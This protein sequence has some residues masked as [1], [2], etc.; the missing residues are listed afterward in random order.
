MQRRESAPLLDG[1]PLV[2]AVL[3]VYGLRIPNQEAANLTKKVITLSLVLLVTQAIIS[4]IQA[5][6]YGSLSPPLPDGSAPTLRRRLLR[7]LQPQRRGAGQKQKSA[8]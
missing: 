4:I 7:E 5:L 2:T 8:A 6:V 3:P 1:T